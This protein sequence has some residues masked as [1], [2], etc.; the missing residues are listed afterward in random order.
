MKS[1]GQFLE[2]KYIKYSHTGEGYNDRG[3]PNREKWRGPHEGKEIDM[4]LD[5]NKP[6]AI[7]SDHQMGP[8]LP[9]I[10]SGK[11]IHMKHVY[12][13]PDDGTR[14]IENSTNIIALKGHEKRMQKISDT[15]H[16]VNGNLRHAK[17]GRLLGYDKS[18]IRKFMES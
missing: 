9:H 2:E 1:F 17:L 4:M 14:F 10:K 15:L 5:G 13:Q 7:K 6:A 18:H 3:D 12:K 8:F 16:N 11:F